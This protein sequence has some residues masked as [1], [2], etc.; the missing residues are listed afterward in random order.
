MTCSFL[1][2]VGCPTLAS[3]PGFKI[4]KPFPSPCTL[5]DAL[6][7]YCDLARA[8]TKKLPLGFGFNPGAVVG[9]YSGT[10]SF[11]RNEAGMQ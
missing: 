1:G 8:P 7:L 6:Y 4:K 10:P 2:E 11:L 9:V 5:R 3:V